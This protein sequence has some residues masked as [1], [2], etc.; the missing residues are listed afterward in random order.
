M[1]PG[2]PPMPGMGHMGP[3]LMV[4]GMRGELPMGN[5][6]GPMGMGPGGMM[7]PRGPPAPP[8]GPPPNPK[9]ADLL[10]ALLNRP[11]AAQRDKVGK[12]ANGF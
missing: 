4:P 3:P 11:T 5:P 8:P 10:E 12:W 7:F 2:P 6:P 9:P 1:V